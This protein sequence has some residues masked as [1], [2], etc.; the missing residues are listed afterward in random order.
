MA[1][2]PDIKIS[3]DEISYFMNYVAER[4][5]VVCATGSSASGVGIDDAGMQV[6]YDGAP[7]GKT[8]VGLLLDDVVNYDLSKQPRNGYKSEA[9]LGEKV[10]L[11][12]KGWVVTNFLATGHGTG[13]LPHKLFLLPGGRFSERGEINA[14]PTGAYEIS[15][16]AASGYPVIGQ[17]M[18]RPDANGFA[19]VWI[20]L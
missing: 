10:C 16:Y 15:G 4:G 5:G 8:P 17:L 3:Q 12:R 6:C 1:L 7:S 19:K 18:T 2:R 13:I 11:L 20:D 9:Q 14:G